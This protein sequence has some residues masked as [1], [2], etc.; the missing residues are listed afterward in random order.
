MPAVP[1]RIQATAGRLLSLGPSRV[2]H[3]PAFRIALGLAIPLSVLLLT[4]RVEW[5]MY[6]GFGAFTGIYSKYEPTR[7][8][9][10]RQSMAGALL[11][12]C[13]TIGATLAQLGESMSE[14]AESWT[15]LGVGSVVAGLAATVV[16]KLGLKPGGAIFPLFAV[17]AIAS[18]PPAAPIWAAFLIAGACASLCVVLG[19]LGHWAGERHPGAGVRTATETWSR[20]QLGAEFGRFAIASAIAGALGLASGL[21]FPYWAQIAAIA[22][23]SAPG[24]TLQ[25]ERGLH[26][27]IGTTLGI[28]TTAFL[29]SFP[30]EAWQLVVW[31]VVLQFLAE[32]Y[33]MRNYSFA[34]LFI[35]PLALL[36][37]QLAH[38]QPIG[39]MLEAR[40][41]ETVIGAGVG[42]AVVIAAALWDRRAA[43]RRLTADAAVRAGGG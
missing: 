23:L 12:V 22:P 19:L 34:L 33:V 1:T 36:M 43:L 2:D 24:R 28:V 27:I 30:A 31:V 6:V 16:L 10:R 4:G 37:V 41:L 18:A 3:I 40:V 42:I 7:M 14:V 29:L 5:A 35:T 39:T 15:A 17:A 26:R 8:R 9:F 13:V 32:M 20:A 11:T 38:P 25:V 21:P